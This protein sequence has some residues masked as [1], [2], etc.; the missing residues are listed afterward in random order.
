MSRV[1]VRVFSH[2]FFSVIFLYFV[3]ICIAVG[4]SI[5]NVV[6]WG[7]ILTG[8]IPPHCC[9]CRKPGPEFP[10]WSAVGFSN[11]EKIS[12]QRKTNH[13]S[14]AQCIEHK[15]TTADHVGN[16]GHT[17]LTKVRVIWTQ[18]KTR[19]EL[20][21]S[22]RVGSSCPT[23]LNKRLLDDDKIISNTFIIVQ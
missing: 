8:L 3:Y 20:M 15:K 1:A 9:A 12:T 22:G 10:T 4:N 11:Y 6:V 2:T 7:P 21:C 14:P 5:I 18:L 17:Q 23:S 19:G 13:L 16:S